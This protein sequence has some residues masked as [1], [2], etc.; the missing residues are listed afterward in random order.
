VLVAR[1]MRI[2]ELNQL[3]GLLPIGRFRG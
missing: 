3:A 1:R 2:Q